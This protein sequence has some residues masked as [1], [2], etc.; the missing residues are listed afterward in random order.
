MD[1]AKNIYEYL[2]NGYN[3]CTKPKP[4]TREKTKSISNSEPAP[5]STLSTLKV[6]VSQKEF[7]E[8]ECYDALISKGRIIV[9]IEK[10]VIPKNKDVST[11]L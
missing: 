2:K 1:R 4:R 9:K 8:T 6:F 11:G 10:H 5:V 7:K 3:I